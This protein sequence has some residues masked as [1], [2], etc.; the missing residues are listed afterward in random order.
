M[1]NPSLP[2]TMKGVQISRNGGV[3]VLEYKTD[4]PVPTP[5]EGEVLIKNEFC[6]V[7][8]IDEWPSSSRSIYDTVQTKPQA[9]Q[10]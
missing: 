1:S 7:N 8:Y 6:G 3:E 2:K 5:A 9:P 10:F 4:M